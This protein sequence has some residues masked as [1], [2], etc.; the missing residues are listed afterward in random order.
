MHRGRQTTPASIVHHSQIA[1]LDQWRLPVVLHPAVMV[2]A[3]VMGARDNRT[4]PAER[5]LTVRL[6]CRCSTTATT[7][8][9]A[10]EVQVFAA[11]LNR[12]L[13]QILTSRRTAVVTPQAATAQWHCT[14]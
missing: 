14:S 5:G 3:H 2:T 6:G 11:I 4:G 9:R 12:L 13:E 8:A 7:A 1:G 10:G